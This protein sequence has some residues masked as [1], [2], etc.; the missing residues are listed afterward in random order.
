MSSCVGG[1][2]RVT[3]ALCC[4][5]ARCFTPSCCGRCVTAQRSVCVLLL[6]RSCVCGFT[7]RALSVR[8]YC[9]LLTVVGG[10]QYSR[11]LFL[12]RDSD[13]GVAVFA[14]Q[15]CCSGPVCDAAPSLF[16]AAVGEA[17]VLPSNDT[18]SCWCGV[19]APLSSMLCWRYCVCRLA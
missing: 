12:H 17:A 9:H 19:V 8:M 3:W 7:A 18:S 15:C 6:D 10:C 1:Q 11:A 14:C 2:W 4:S 16:A 13:C 5:V